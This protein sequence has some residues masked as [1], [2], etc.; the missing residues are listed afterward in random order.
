M[1]ASPSYALARA[2]R[3]FDRVLQVLKMT[4]PARSLSDGIKT[5]SSGTARAGDPHARC[6]ARTS[7]PASP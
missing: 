2:D 7:C 1:S 3:V 6:R 5:A 4:A